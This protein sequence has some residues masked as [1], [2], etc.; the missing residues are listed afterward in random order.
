ME[1]EAI[2]P[3]LLYSLGEASTGPERI[4]MFLRHNPVPDRSFD[5]SSSF[6]QS[7]AVPVL[8]NLKTLL[9]SL[10][11]RF[12]RAANMYG[13]SDP[14]NPDPGFDC[15]RRFLQYTPLLEHIRLNF[16]HNGLSEKPTDAFLAWLSTSPG[17]DVNM[18]PTPVKLDHLTTLELGM[19]D[20]APRTL[21]GLVSK[22]QKL[23]AVSLW[24][25]ELKP[26]QVNSD[27]VEDGGRPLWSYYL[28]KISEAFHTPENIKSFM[29]GWI[30]EPD[31]TN[32]IRSPKPLSFAG[33]T[34]IDGNGEK[35]FEDPEDVVK[36]RKRVGSNVCTWL[37][38]LAEKAFLPPPIEFDGSDD[39]EDEDIQD[40]RSD[41]TDDVVDLS[42][43]EDDGSVDTET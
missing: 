20:I 30:T 25:V 41:D 1:S 21:L 11:G 3:L 24:K 18:T 29:I 7:E 19:I 6:M 10:D 17:P 43:S 9:L 39:D 37:E 16:R 38:E 31:T 23:E 4:E 12:D 2:L 14:S 28:R 34:N 15:L 36:Y 40:D 8:S 33:K 5:L 42:E 35:T 32:R 22:F 26:N 13:G 27:L